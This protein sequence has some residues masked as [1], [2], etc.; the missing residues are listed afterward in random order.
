MQIIKDNHQT[1][2]LSQAV[3]SQLKTSNKHQLNIILKKH[4]QTKEVS[5]AAE[6]SS[7]MSAYESKLIQ[8]FATTNQAKIFCY[9]NDFAKSDYILQTF[10]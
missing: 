6:I 8:D 9:I 4:L 7:A 10:S 2:P 1:E 5:L 3:Y